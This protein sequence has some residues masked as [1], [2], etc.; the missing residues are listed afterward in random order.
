M[1]IDGQTVIL[2]VYILFI[3]LVG[4]H[5]FEEISHGVIGAFQGIVRTIG[6]F[7]AGRN[8]TGLGVGFFTAMP[9]S[10]AGI[11]VFILLLR[12]MI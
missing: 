5:T 2:L 3:W 12:S 10:L 4:L 11:A 8:T 6:Y 7:R 9:L 1:N